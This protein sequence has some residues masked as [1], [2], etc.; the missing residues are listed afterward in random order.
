MSITRKFLKGMGLTDEQVDTIIEAHTETVDGLK[1]DVDKYREDAIKLPD[2]QKELN[3]L[4]AAG[5]GGLQKQLD[6]LQKKY[7]TEAAAH[8]AELEKLQG[9][10]AER[11]YT[12]AIGKAIAGANDGKGLKFSSKAARTAFE[13]AIREKK[14]EMKDGALTG[15]DDFVKAQ[16]EADPDAFASDKPA[17]RFVSPVGVGNKPIEGKS[18]AAQIAEEMHNNLYG[19]A[20]KE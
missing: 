16:K 17:P 2:V 8:K 20:K 19:T 15:F 3:D 14:L 18:R 1:A 6:D 13:A 9:Q 5:D 12:D 11:D 4:K 7:D 10:L